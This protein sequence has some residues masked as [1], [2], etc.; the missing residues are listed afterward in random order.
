MTYNYNTNKTLAD[1]V[2]DILQHHDTSDRPGRYEYDPANGIIKVF[3][4]NGAYSVVIRNNGH[5]GR[6]WNDALAAARAAL[7]IAVNE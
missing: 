7:W 2:C 5:N 4:D 1:Y 6:A 3:S